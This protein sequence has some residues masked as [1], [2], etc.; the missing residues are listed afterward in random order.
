[1]FSNKCVAKQCLSVY[2][3][4]ASCSAVAVAAKH[5][6][7]GQ[8]RALGPGLDTPH[9]LKEDRGVRFELVGAIEQIETIAAGLGVTVRSF[10]ARRMAAAGGGSSRESPSSDCR[11]ASL[12]TP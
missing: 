8:A 7:I 3:H 6:A 9:D 5:S 10:L 1:M 2:D 4:A 12:E 11:T